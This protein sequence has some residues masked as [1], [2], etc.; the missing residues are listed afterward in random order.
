MMPPGASGL[1]STGL[2]HLYSHARSLLSTR[3][4]KMCATGCPK[5]MLPRMRH[6]MASLQP[7]KRPEQKTRYTQRAHGYH[8][9]LMPRL[10]RLAA[11]AS[12]YELAARLAFAR[13]D[14]DG[15][16]MLPA[17]ERPTTGTECCESPGRAFGSGSSSA[18]A[19]SSAACAAMYCSTACTSAHACTPSPVLLAMRSPHQRGMHTVRAMR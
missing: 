1:R 16:T 3:N 5:R 9:K 11:I 6:R 2:P 10:R 7:S 18:A 17:C 12:W 4:W 14:G 19:S 13:S 8:S 15:M